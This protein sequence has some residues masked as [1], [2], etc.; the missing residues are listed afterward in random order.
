M[1]P[2]QIIDHN[3]PLGGGGMGCVYKAMDTNNRVVALKMMSNRLTCYPTYRQLFNQEVQTLKGLNHKYVVHII[4]EPYEDAQ[5]N[6]YLPME[7][8]DGENIE[9]YVP[10]GD[11][12]N[13]K[14]AVKLMIKILD[15][16]EY[17]HGE[18]V[19]HRDI[20]PANIMIR[21]NEDVCVVDFGIAKDASVGASG[22]TVGTI[23]GTDGYMSPEQAD[24]LNIDT[25]TDIYSLGCVFFYLL[26]GQHAVKKENNDNATIHNILEGTM[27]SPSQIKSSIPQSVDAVFLKSVHKNMTKRYQTATEFK[28]ALIN[29]EDNPNPQIS[30][31]R[32]YDNDIQITDNDH[33]VSRHHLVISGHSNGSIEIKDTSTNGTNING[34]LIKNESIKINSVKTNPP[35]VLLA[36]LHEC[37]LNWD[38]VMQKLRERGWNPPPPPSPNVRFNIFV[39][40]LCFLLPLVGWLLGGVWKT[41]HPQKASTVFT[42]AWVSFIIYIIIFA[43]L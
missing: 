8:I 12:L 42:I 28:D 24:G 7:Y 18:G 30:V 21:N 9:K 31:G 22:H 36:A 23:I 25:R 2:Y 32:D 3:N 16:M 26:T 38:D 33:K 27:R 17:I 43:I 40:I 6:Y 10:N 41:E 11:G 29:I 5:G 37:Q 34:R 14:D 19:I 39:G 20:K 15:A 4:G 35:V 1:P 13:Y